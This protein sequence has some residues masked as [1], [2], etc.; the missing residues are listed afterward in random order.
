MR[1]DD[2][3]RVG[4][5]EITVM[6]Y[7][8]GTTMELA[9]KSGSCWTATAPVRAYPQLQGPG[10]ADVAVVGAGIV[11]LTAAYILSGA[12]LSVVVLEASQVGRQVTGRSTAKITS[13]HALIYR[14]LIETFNLD[15]A[16]RYADANRTASQQ[17]RSWIEDLRIDCDFEVKDAYAYTSDPARLAE[18]ESE[19]AAA[20]SVGFDTDVLAKAPL[21]F[22]TA[23]ALRFSNQAQFNPA[24]YLVGLAK[25]IESAGGSIFENTPVTSVDSSNRWQLKAG[26]A[27]LDV[28]HVVMATNLPMAGSVAYD[29]RTRP[30]CHIAMAFRTTRD[31]VIDGMFI[32]IDAPTHSLR[33]GR[34]GDGPLLVALGPTF[35][36]GHDGDVSARFRQLESWVRRNVPVG[37]AAW[38]WVN[39]DY[40]TVDRVPYVGVP[41]AE[42]AGFYVATG[43]NGWGIS[44]GTAAG[45]VIA[46][47]ILGRSN[48]WTAL[49]DPTRPSP[50]GFNQGGET[51]SRVSSLD[52]ILPGQGG[53]LTIGKEDVAIWK[54]DDGTPY[55]FSAS[56][57]HKGCTVTWNN[58]DR[59][60]DCP[61]HGSIFGA[62]GLVIHGPAVEP[63]A[64]RD[65]PII[66]PKN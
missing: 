48:P 35:N 29:E 18:I 64:A 50:K 5:P 27:V 33:M 55:A 42:V 40:N 56:C 17:I 1:A 3:Q 63:L 60:W 6:P 20:R 54:A 32:G 65:L 28:Q 15:I 59:T 38:R 66:A 49:Y 12:G 19:A 51:Q 57:T 52:D 10:S 2:F 11:G 9:G 30:R 8:I 16:Q 36:T 34:D 58:A 21:P 31:A 46:D 14:H 7:R 26:G 22:E 61:C 45:M 43:F 13:Q 47:Q 23:G 44:N 25:A 39:E 37:D 62:D 41:S 24:S 53:V 4:A